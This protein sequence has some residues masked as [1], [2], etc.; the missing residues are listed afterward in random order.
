MIEGYTLIRRERTGKETV[1]GPKGY[2][3]CLV[4]VKQTIKMV[5]MNEKFEDYMEAIWLEICIHSQRMMIG[6]LYRH[7]KDLESYKKLDKVLE[8]IPTRRKN[9]TLIGDLNSELSKKGGPD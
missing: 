6:T 7:P 9:P 3:G 5:P 1:H 2:C 4:Y 8:I